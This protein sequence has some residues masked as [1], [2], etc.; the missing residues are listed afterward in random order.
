MRLRCETRTSILR[1]AGDDVD[2]AGDAVPPGRY[3]RVNPYVMAPDNHW[4]PRPR[5]PE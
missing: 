3:R 5:R 4:D 1:I 2:A